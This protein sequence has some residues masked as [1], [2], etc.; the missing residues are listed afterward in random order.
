MKIL[1]YCI[2]FVVGGVLSVRASQNSTVLP[3]QDRKD[4]CTDR[5]RIVISGIPGEKPLEISALDL[6]RC[7]S[8]CKDVLVVNVLGKRFWEDARIKGSIC[9]PLKELEQEAKKWDKNQKIVVYCACKQ[10]DASA[11]AYALLKKMGFKKVLAYEGGIREWYQNGL[12]CEGPCKYEY[13]VRNDDD[14]T[15]NKRP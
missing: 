9:A 2:F 7:M 3:E 8:H 4:E 13:L 10:C 5:T 14:R 6:L 1:R 12:P 15:E 11:K